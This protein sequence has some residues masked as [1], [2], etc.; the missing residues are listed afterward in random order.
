MTVCE[1]SASPKCLSVLSGSSH[2]PAAQSQTNLYFGHQSNLQCRNCKYITSSRLVRPHA[3]VLPSGIE[4]RRGT[5][6]AHEQDLAGLGEEVQ[7]ERPRLLAHGKHKRLSSELVL[8]AS[9]ND[10]WLN[11]GFT[12]E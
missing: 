8:R 5:L 3:T 1:Y 6:S 2:A 10:L 4:E 11:V 12:G 7:D 9:G